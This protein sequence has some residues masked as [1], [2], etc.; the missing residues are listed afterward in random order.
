MQRRVKAMYA[1]ERLIKR[2]ENLYE[3]VVNHK[4]FSLA[5]KKA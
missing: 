1:W 2:Y 3:Q 4:A 5:P